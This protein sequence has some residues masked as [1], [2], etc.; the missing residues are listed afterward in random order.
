MKKGEGTV[1]GKEVKAVLFDLDGVLVDSFEAWLYVFNDTR[2]D[3]GLKTVPK[4][5]FAK[6]FGAPIERDVRKYFKGKTIK[7]VE[8]A[9]N[10]NFRNRRKYVKLAS[11][12]VTALENLRKSKIKI[13]LITNSTYFITYSI[14]GNFR[15]KK[16][17]DAVVT[18]DDIK[19]RKPAPDMIL[20]ACKI[21]KVKPKN[22]IL[23]GDTKNDMIAGKRAGCITVG[24]RTKGNYEIKEL[25][26]IS[27]FLK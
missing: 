15:L 18:M 22:T 26:S 9:Y 27:N 25:N 6:D 12:S 17:F 5:E 23:V 16:Y 24:Y 3:F 13:G 21:L 4:K 19:R 1:Q 10:L 14:L 7:E 2:K 20:K 11:Q 8:K